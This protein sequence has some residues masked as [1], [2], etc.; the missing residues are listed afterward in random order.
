M[1]YAGLNSP[2]MFGSVPGIL[3]GQFEVSI[4][5]LASRPRRDQLSSPRSL[6]MLVLPG[7]FLLLVT[8][9]SDE[10]A[11]SPSTIVG[12][13]R[14]EAG[15]PLAEATVF[16]DTAVPRVGVGVLC[17]SCYPDCRK[18]AVSDAAGQFVLKD[19]DPNLKFRLLAFAR[20]HQP[21]FTEKAIVSEA[22]R[23]VFTLKAH[24][25]DRR[26][27]NRVVRGR[28]VNENGDPVGRAVIEPNGARRGDS[29]QFGGM[30]E[31]GIDPLAVSDDDGNFA[32]GVASGFDQLLV[33]VRA[34]YLAPKRAKLTPGDA[35]VASITLGVGVTVTGRLLSDGRPLPGVALGMVQRDRSAETFLGS[36]VFGTNDAGRF[37][38]VNVPTHDDLFLYGLMDSLKAY[39]SLK[40]R[41]VRTESHGQ[42]I[43]MG[44]LTVEPG[45][46]L[47]GRVVLSDGKPLP[48]NTRLLL[49]RS[50]AWDTQT[51]TLGDDGGFSFTGVPDEIVDLNISVPGYHL[52]KRNH[53][54]D[55]YGRALEG[56]VDTDIDGLTIVFEPGDDGRRSFGPIDNAAY[57][58]YR[59]R[60]ATRI[61]GIGT[62]P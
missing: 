22:G 37:S 16:V 3:I 36:L 30:V 8:G 50:E 23:V 26:E 54:V 52:S 39:G 14:D 35:E 59:K 13:V 45:F 17:P 53:G 51:A 32:L 10:P 7:L 56:R 6:A 60:R 27:A 61:S 38:F 18:S 1:S 21:T 24:D 12:V 33:V 44:E 62:E 2:G 40:A 11:P 41:L 19:L 57:E 29:T 58:E 20:N 31:L 25:L 42:T 9:I 46:R 4:V 15:R 55:L 49:N 48:A 47:A 43:D 5:K 28:V 34:P